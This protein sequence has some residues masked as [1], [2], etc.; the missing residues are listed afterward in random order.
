MLQRDYF[1]R[2]IEEFMAAIS[3]FLEKKEDTRQRQRDLE[4][5][6]RQYVGDYSLL[7][8]MTFDELLDYAA[9]E[10]KPEQRIEKLQMVAYLL[11]AES[12]T[13]SG[14]LRLMLLDKAFMLFDYV[15]AN[16]STFSLPRKQK[17]RQLEEQR[18]GK[19]KPDNAG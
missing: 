7:R 3:R 1:I 17:L 6:Y 18:H 13:K 9:H 10:Y 12:Q 19:H 8:N 15:D 14:P 11:D 16:D 2:I 5:L 4:D